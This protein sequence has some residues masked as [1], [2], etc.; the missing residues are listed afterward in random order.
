MSNLFIDGEALESVLS[1]GTTSVGTVSFDNEEESLETKSNFV[2]RS[3]TEIELGGAGRSAVFLQY[4]TKSGKDF[5]RVLES[6]DGCP[7]LALYLRLS[8]SGLNKELFYQVMQN[9]RSMLRIPEVMVKGAGSELWLRVSK[10]AKRQGFS[11]GRLGQILAYR[12]KK[13]YPEI[14]SVG[15]II[16]N[17]DDNQYSLMRDCAEKF[18]EDSEVLKADVWKSRGFDF[19]DCHVLGHCGRCSDRNL[20]AN[21]RHIERLSELGKAKTLE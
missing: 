5:V 4:W 21:V 2:L 11:L 17:T 7:N 3:N 20:C 19:S 1:K 12:I 18:V 14:E 9:F 13:E 15:V 16:I 10:Q 8:G 6:A